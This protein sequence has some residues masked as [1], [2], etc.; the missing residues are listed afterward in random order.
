M[1]SIRPNKHPNTKSFDAIFA[2]VRPSLYKAL[3]N[4]IGKPT[5]DCFAAIAESEI[6]SIH[7]IAG[8]GVATIKHRLSQ[9]GV[10]LWSDDTVRYSDRITMLYTR[11]D[12]T[13]PAHFYRFYI[14]AD[15]VLDDILV[16]LG[17]QFAELSLKEFARYCNDPAE[18]VADATIAVQAHFDKKWSDGDVA[19]AIGRFC[20]HFDANLYAWSREALL[21]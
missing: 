13:I 3:V 9:H 16:A 5:A 1:L 6:R 18:F 12:D 15:P 2:D 21:A 10:E 19:T 20:D 8:A 17:E 7:G 11:G 4:K 14:K